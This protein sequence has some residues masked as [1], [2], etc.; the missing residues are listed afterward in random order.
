MSTPNSRITCTHCR[1]SLRDIP[2]EDKLIG[3]IRAIRTQT[4]DS[5]FSLDKC[6]SYFLEIKWT[7]LKIRFCFRFYLVLELF[8]DVRHHPVILIAQIIS[9]TKLKVIVE[10]TRPATS[11]FLL[12][13]QNNRFILKHT[14]KCQVRLG[15]S[16]RV[17]YDCNQRT[18]GKEKVRTPGLRSF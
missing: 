6:F 9:L 11:K 7:N 17:N 15:E 1:P 2:P 3:W 5:C 10:V 12:P 18:V 8:H 13:V 16:Q 4:Q 14:N